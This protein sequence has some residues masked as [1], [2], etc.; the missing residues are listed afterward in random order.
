[1]IDFD[2]LMAEYPADPLALAWRD[3]SDL[4]NAH[5]LIALTAG[6]LL[7]EP[8]TGWLAYNGKRW[9]REAG[10]QLA[11][12]AAHDVAAHVRAEAEAL[13]AHAE[14]QLTAREIGEDHPIFERVDKLYGWATQSGNAGRTAAMLVQA[15]AYLTIGAEALDPDPLALCVDNGVVRLRREAGDAV[16]VRR[17]DHDPRALMTRIAV[18]SYDPAAR[19]PEWEAHLERVLPDPFVRQ[20]F[21]AWMGYAMTAGNSEQRILLLQGKGRDGKSTSM[22]V[23]RRVLGGYAVACDVK[24]FLELGQRSGADAS[25]D[26]AR[27]AGDVRLVSTSEPPPNGRLNEGL[28]KAITGGAPVL[29]RFL[30]RNPFEYVPAFKLVIE[31][32][33]KPRI[34]GADDGIWR[35]VDL[36]EFRVQIPESEVDRGLEDRIVQTEAAGVLN[37]LIDGCR[38]WLTEG[39]VPPIPVREA[40]AEYR[41]ASNPFVEWLADRVEF[42]DGEV[43]KGSA[44]YRDYQDWCRFN[45]AEAKSQ[46]AFGLMLSDRQINHGPKDRAGN[47]TRRGVRLHP[48]PVEWDDADGQFPG[49]YGGR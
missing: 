10:E 1:M 20:Y 40:V 39:L 46:R 21:Q 38:L 34:G 37:W 35:R 36:I 3:M 43:V 9:D 32:N 6:R 33:T 5:R 14:A 12:R 28:I 48:R 49:G 2:G 42:V 41:R 11:H 44:L 19:A 29:A 18:A 16:D 22:N 17:L 47:K 15:Q 31:C 30:N 7:H 24:T 26:M 8:G 4:G 23:I 13:E 25:P 45:E 27:L